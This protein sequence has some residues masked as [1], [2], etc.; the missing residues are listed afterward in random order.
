MGLIRQNCTFVQQ[1][2]RIKSIMGDYMIENKL[3]PS[4]YELE[5]SD[6]DAE[7]Y[8]RYSQEQV[9]NQQSFEHWQKGLPPLLFKYRSVSTSL[10]LVRVIDIIKDKRLYVPVADSV[11][12]PFEGGNIDYLAEEDREAFESEVKK[13]RVLSL[14]KDCFSSPLW[15]HYSNG[16]TG[17]CLGFSTFD[18]LSC[19]EELIYTNTIDKKQWWSVDKSD[20]VRRDFLYKNQDWKYESE[21]RIIRNTAEKSN[22]YLS[23]EPHELKL[24][25]FGEKMDKEIKKCLKELVPSNVLTLDIK[26]DKN[27]KRYYLTKV[28]SDD[29]IAYTLDELY[30]FI[31]KP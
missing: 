4:D 28:E 23:F 7:L 29:S 12:D 14:S 16:C 2:F 10:N 17:I 3:E 5:R 8:E 11:N 1:I 22:E 27:R 6:R 21:Y 25:I 24:V 26:A 31:F 18:T 19:A 20:A 15:A 30:K 9:C 13:C